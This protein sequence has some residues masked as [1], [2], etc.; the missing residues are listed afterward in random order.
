M[1][2][3]ISFLA[4]AL[5]TGSQLHAQ[6]TT[7]SAYVR[8]YYEKTE[9]TVPMRDGKKLFTVIYSPK[10]KTKKYPI[11][12][13]RTPYTVG[14]YGQ[15]EYKKSL[16]N[17]PSMMRDGYIF[18]YQ[19]V[20][21]K[22]MSEG[23]FEDVRPTN[24]SKDKKAIDESTDTYDALEW[25][26]KN[27]K[28]YNGK[29]GLYGISYPGFY[30]TVGL[31]KTHPSLK[32]VSPQAPVTDWFIGD[33]FHH[34]GVL[35]LQ[36]AFTFMSTFGV[37]RPKPITPDQFKSNIQINEVD[38]YNF[39]LEGGTAK[40]LKEKY[41]GDSVKFWNDLFKHPNYDEFWKSRV[42]TNYLQDVKPAVM[43]VG[44]FFDAEDAY[45]TFKTY[46]SIEEKSKTNN[47]IL[48]AGPWY[49]GGWVRA[50]GDHLGDIQFE[51]KTSI[52]YQE[53]FEQPFF[54]HYLK[55]EG[56]FSPAE[57]NIFISGS[58]EWKQFKQWPPKNVE[59]KKL[60]FQ[61]QGKLG[62]EKVQR[63]DSWDEYVTDPNKP[64]PHQGGL[65]QNRTREYMVD[66]QRFAA[67]RPDVMVYQTAA[68]TED[69]TIVG[70]IKNFL[71]VSST[72]TD[73]DYVV[74][75]ID[76]YPNDAPSFEGKTMAGYQ[77]MVRGEIMAGKYRNGFDKP[78]AL[79]PGLVEKV[80]FL[81][82]DVAHTFKKGHRIMVQV[83]NSWFPL[84]E[85]NPQVFM[86][87]YTAT[88]AD[89]RK[90]TQRIFHDVNNA[91]YIEFDI[92]KD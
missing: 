22:W 54:S 41:F 44:G 9:V 1:K 91:T 39:F 63:T 33:D 60:Y 79:T 48:V 87:P 52:T 70:P 3:T 75:L 47:S 32:A 68:L 46:Q 67:N 12:L 21:G 80:D 31:V 62:F 69:I 49:H 42:I 40:E 64:V 26:Q 50:A 17:F 92:L 72:G 23:D 51:K 83:Q 59:T 82:P 45:G 4:L 20:R 43:V 53:K 61:P 90:A 19:D 38:K 2:T 37:P 86:E 88:K 57:A 55:E 65:I 15:N 85:R 16:G 24:L 71:K 13:N 56:S 7:D 35:F 8:D 76:V 5:L 29:A 25:L 11:L 14:P 27:V 78:Q 81:M 58:N 34:N 77:M 74:K 10:D 89:F 6:T 84:A 73:A 30:S 66:D 36:D 28:N 18:V